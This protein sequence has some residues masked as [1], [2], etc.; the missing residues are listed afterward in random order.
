MDFNQSLIALGLQPITY[1][2]KTAE[3]DTPNRLIAGMRR[4][5]EKEALFYKMIL[6]G[7]KPQVFLTGQWARPQSREVNR[8][9]A[10]KKKVDVYITTNH[11]CGTRRN[12]KAVDELC[13]FRIDMDAGKDDKGNYLALSVVAERKSEM[14]KQIARMPRY[15]AL[16]ET[17]N[18]YHVYWAIKQDAK[19]NIV[20]W[21]AIQER[22]V[23][24]TGADPVVKEPAR[25]MRMPYTFAM[26]GGMYEPFLV[27][28][29]DVN[30]NEYDPM[31]LLANF[32]EDF[33]PNNIT[34]LT[35]RRS[36]SCSSG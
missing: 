12:D 33:A 36:T 8:V 1:W 27:R 31:E 5:K 19:I 17:R 11:F 32:E 2:T 29:V 20:E 18:G 30:E 13:C 35:V 21:K 26:K 34:S 7:R 22:I 25:L 23:K 3:V 14:R 28:I 10:L 24:L 15:T 4:I 16:N 9:E 6:R